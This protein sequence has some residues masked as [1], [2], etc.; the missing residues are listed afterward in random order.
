MMIQDIITQNISKNSQE[1]QKDRS[2]VYW[3]G[4]DVKI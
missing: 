2:Q 3:A 4:Y 1:L